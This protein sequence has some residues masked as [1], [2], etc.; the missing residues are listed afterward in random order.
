MDQAE[1]KAMVDSY[2]TA[3]K[4]RRGHWW[5]RQHQSEIEAVFKEIGEADDEVYGKSEDE[6]DVA[7]PAT[8]A[9][10]RHDHEAG[11]SKGAGDGEEKYIMGVHRCSDTRKATAL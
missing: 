8:P 5:Y 4:F 11:T 2:R 10:R 9:P 1:E 6:E 7:S 3:Y